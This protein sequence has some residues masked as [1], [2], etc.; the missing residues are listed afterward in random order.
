MCESC[1]CENLT[2]AMLISTKSGRR[3]VN[4][5]RQWSVAPGSGRA[6][7]PPEALCDPRDRDALHGSRQ[8]REGVG[9]N[10]L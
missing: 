2:A 6:R 8:D 7:F 1:V 9:T 3:Q 4:I 10:G 5:V